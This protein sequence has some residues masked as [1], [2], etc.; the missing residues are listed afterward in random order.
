VPFAADE[1]ML[2]VSAE[3][4]GVLWTPMSFFYAD[5]GTHSLRLSCSYLEPELI[6]EGVRRL[7]RFVVET[8]GHRSQAA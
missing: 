7:S 2:R 6:A 5:G 1:E 4:Y 3:R 8:A